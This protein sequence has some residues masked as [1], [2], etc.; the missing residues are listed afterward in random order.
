MFKSQIKASFE[1]NIG[2]RSIIYGDKG[3]LDIIDTWHGTDVIEKIIN[4]KKN[5]IINKFTDNPYS[6][7]IESISKHL[8]GN[9]NETS[10]PGF[11]IQDTL[12]NTKIL[13]SWLN[14]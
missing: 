10:Y 13:E 1:N 3:S 6:F 9:N 5:R 12:L 8:L 7:Q 2:K 14:V 4:G 11:T